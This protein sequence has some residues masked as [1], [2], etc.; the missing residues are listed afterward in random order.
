[1][2]TPENA[3]RLLEWMNASEVA[4]TLGVS[5]QSVHEMIRAG[6]FKTLHVSG[7]PSQRPAYYVKRVEVEQIKSTRVFPRAR[8]RNP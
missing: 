3:P 4:E 8:P 5:R 2:T 1:V 7:L 6:E